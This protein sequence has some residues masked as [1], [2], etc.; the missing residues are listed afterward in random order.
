MK[1]TY[2]RSFTLFSVFLFM[3][4]ILS[5]SGRPGKKAEAAVNSPA[6][7]VVEP[8]ER[9]IKMVTPDENTGFKLHEPVKVVLEL[10]DERRLPDSIVIYFDGKRIKSVVSKPYEYLIPPVYTVSTGR[11]SLKATAFRDGKPQNTI[12]RFMVIFSDI[13]PK[14]YGY[15]VVNS[16][17]HDR[18]AFTQGL[19]F[20]HGVF[21]EGTG[22]KAESTLREVD[23][24]TGRVLRQHNLDAALFGEGITLYND[25]IFQVTWENKV[26]FVYDRATF[27]QLNKIFYQTQGWGLTTVDNRIVMSDGTNVLYFLEPETFTVTSSLEVYDNSKK[28]DQLNELEYIEGEIWANIWTSDQIARIDPQSGKVL[29]Y[30]NLKGILPRSEREP[31]TDVL[32]GIAYDAQG[33]RIFVTGKR[34]PKLYEIQV[35]G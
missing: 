2:S 30:I 17:P 27:R 29:G 10:T 28:V 33:K 13:V 16:Y 8:A 21:Y 4:A 12:T 5:C 26:G 32:N 11:K 24:S 6:A 18:D 22:Q 23:P 34:W 3:T 35:T 25:M 20:D 19:I 1:M 31:E 15:R 14:S 9:L 7:P